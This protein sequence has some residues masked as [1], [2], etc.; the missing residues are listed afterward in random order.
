MPK[1]YTKV[2]DSGM[3]SLYDMR[4]VSKADWVFKVLGDFDELSAHIGLLCCKLPDDFSPQITYLRRIQSMLLNFGSNFATMHNREKI[5]KTTEADVK[6]IENE[7]DF[8]DGSCPKLTE[9]IL[10]GIGETDSIAHVCR[11]V[12]RRAERNVWTLKDLGDETPVEKETFQYLNRLSDY[13]FAL[14]RFLVYKSGK[15]E[16]KRSEA[17]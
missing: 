17:H 7:I 13:F 15:K 3:S 11:A 10:P 1:L 12:C 9:F 2:G 8:L 4:N 16:I 6:N 5:V 14:A